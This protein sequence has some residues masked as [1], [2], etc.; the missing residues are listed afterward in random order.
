MIQVYIADTDA[1]SHP[2]TFRHYMDRIDET[3]REKVWQ[4][5]KEEDRK[6]SLL[7]GYL[8]QVGMKERCVKESGGL[9]DTAPLSLSYAY[10]ENGKPYFSDYPQIKFSLSHS[11]NYVVAAFDVEEIGIDI[12]YRKQLRFHMAERFFSPED[13][14]LLDKLGENEDYLHF[15]RMWTVK[16]A[17]MKLTGEGL[18]QGLDRT[19]VEPD[20]RDQTIGRIRKRNS[21]EGAYYKLFDTLAEKYSIAVCSSSR[22]SDIKIKEVV[23]AD[24]KL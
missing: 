20:V 7:A 19:V 9:A 1:L 13:K 8:I 10:G 11:E 2:E 23:L 4:C 5:R 18:Q 3:R 12:Q 16:E 15:Y 22:I 21:Q 14:A 17:Y 24:E 6:R